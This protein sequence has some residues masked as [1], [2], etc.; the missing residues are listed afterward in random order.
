MF[1]GAVYAFCVCYFPINTSV[2]HCDSEI[3]L[4]LFQRVL[5]LTHTHTRTERSEVVEILNKTTSTATH[6]I[7]DIVYDYTTTTK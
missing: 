2:D 6:S 3:V 1:D 7:Y 4:Y 5:A